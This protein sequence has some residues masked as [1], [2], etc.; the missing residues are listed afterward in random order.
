MLKVVISGGAGTLGQAVAEHFA[1]QGHDVTILTRKVKPNLPHRQLIW[2]GRD[3]EAS[4]GAELA[5]CLLV[6]LAGELVDRRPTKSNI[7]LLKTS[8]TEPTRALGEAAA[9]FG[10]PALWLQMSTLA[11]YGDAGDVILTETS[12]AADGPRQMTDVAK[13]WEAAAPANCAERLVVLRTAVVL[14]PDSPALNRLLTI[15]R[16]FLGGTVASGRQWVSWI[17]IDDFLRAL[18]FIVATP[19]LAGIIHITA[20]E[21]VTNR[22]MMA[23]LRRLLRRPPTP[24]TPAWAIKLGSRLIFNTDAGL[25]LTGRRALPSRLT[26]LGFRFEHGEFSEALAELLLND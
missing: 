6:N 13:A 5:G 15:T 18:D 19:T 8:R 4:W 24:A 12:P 11:I 16:W 26:A 22:K 2:N 23:T 3:A 10:R 9:R 20:P 1:A 21:P 25:A 7:E 14:Q 17:H